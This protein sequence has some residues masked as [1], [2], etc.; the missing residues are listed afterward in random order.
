MH[1]VHIPTIF[2]TSLKCFSLY[3]FTWWSSHK[4]RTFLSISFGCFSSPS[5]C[6]QISRVF[7]FFFFLFSCRVPCESLSLSLSSRRILCDFLTKHLLFWSLHFTQFTCHCFKTSMGIHRYL[8]LLLFL[9]FAD[10][11]DRVYTRFCFFIASFV[12]M[13]WNHAKPYTNTL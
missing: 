6:S 10:C 4:Y 13:R 9:V 2:F 8:Y 1:R 7:F 3:I 5:H 11:S 12:C